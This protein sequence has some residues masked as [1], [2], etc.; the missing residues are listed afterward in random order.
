M[1]LS[2]DPHFPVLILVAC[3]I[4]RSSCSGILIVLLSCKHRFSM[5][6][7]SRADDDRTLEICVS[8]TH[9]YSPEIWNTVKNISAFHEKGIQIDF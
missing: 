5:K 2:S 6:Y 4:I 7:R 3:Y 8:G 1:C 9:P